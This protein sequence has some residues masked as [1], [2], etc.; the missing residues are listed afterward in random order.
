MHIKFLARGTGSARD[1]ADYLLGER[2]ATGQP[3]EGVEVL[4]GD[5]HRVAAVADTLEFEHRY[6]SG[7][8]ARAPDD[9]PT[10]E[11]IEA[12]LD[13][14]EK[15]AWAGLESDRYDWAAVLH[16]ERGGGAH[17]HVLA[18][19]CDLETGRSL[20]IAPPGWRKTFD[21]LRD[22]FNHEH[23]WSRPDDPAR[24]RVQQPGHRAYVEAARL[25]TGLALEAEPR[26]LIR[27]YLLQR[28]EHGTVRNRADVVGALREAGL[29]VPRQGKDYITALDPETGDRWR[30]K[31]ELYG[32]NFERERFDRAAAE[33]AGE[34]T[35]GDRGVD[36]E[37][38]RAAR[39]ELAA[40]REKRAAYH[41]ARYGGGDRADAR[42]TGQGVAPTRQAAVFASFLAECWGCMAD[43][44]RSDTGG[45]S[46]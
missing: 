41:R 10:D 30:L 38:A 6:T 14:F 35:P 15:T 32:E 11:Q 37:R 3:R 27:D 1:A 12:V 23:G 31:G 4:R 34:R 17:V 22:A 29:E 16:R 36:R 7:V 19:R 18:A 24:A 13:A 46:A 8:I 21:P 33:T 5:P 2:D 25:R 43:H 9:Q 20:N 40:R 44:C 39:R 28:V 45:P 42:V 26:D